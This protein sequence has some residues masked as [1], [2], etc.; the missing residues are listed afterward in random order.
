MSSYVV[1]GA[2]R[3]LGLE[4]VRQLSS[5][6]NNRVYAIVRSRNNIQ[7]LQE[8][9][10]INVKIFVAD[11]TSRQQLKEAEADIMS[12]S[13]GC[14]DFLIANAVY[15]NYNYLNDTLEEL[16]NKP[17]IL[18]SELSNSFNTNVIGL[19]NTIN[20]FLPALRRGEGK[21]VA[22]LSTARADDKFTII[23]QDTLS[24]AYQSSK[25]A[26][27]H[28]VLQYSIQYKK[29]GLMF[30]SISPGWVEN[31][32]GDATDEQIAPFLEIVRRYSP[33][34]TGPLTLEESIRLTLGVIHGFGLEQSGQFLSHF[35]N[36]VWI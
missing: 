7:D 21:K 24:A 25:A 26:A 10:R 13:G 1:T 15:V 18:E 35:G 12:D 31:T 27:N 22:V 34:C 8:L 2:A 11:I 19:A 16:E 6:S 17:E 36:Q 29:E 32:V 5:N 20:T 3:G 23:T 9:N 28:L 30:L 33:D 14:L 4:F